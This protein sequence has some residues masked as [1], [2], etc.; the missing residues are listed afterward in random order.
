MTSYAETA[1]TRGLNWLANAQQAIAHNLAN[2][3]SAGFKRRHAI[4][5]E[6][7]TAFH[8]VLEQTLPTVR[9]REVC[10]WRTGTLQATNDPGHVALESG[11]FFRVRGPDGRMYFTRSG[12]LHTDAQGFLCDQ[13]GYRY[14]D[15]TGAEVQ[16]RSEG[17]EAPGVLVAANGALSDARDG[18]SLQRSLGVFRVADR[19][20]LVPAGGGRFVDTRAQEPVVVPTT[21]VRQGSI[22]GSNVETVG[23]LVQ[24]LVVQ[25]AFQ[26][27]ASV[28]RGFGELQSTFIRAVNR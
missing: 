24:M 20:A 4:A 6:S 3:N 21:A 7:P 8:S 14:L 11:D 22:E 23:E 25:R 27:T 15:E 9:Y 18:R 10:D 16:I 5:E 19:D 13:S 1:L 2:V 26:A 17:D 28:L 12:E